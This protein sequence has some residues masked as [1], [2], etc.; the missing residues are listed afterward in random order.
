LFSYIPNTAETSFYGLVKQLKIFKSKKKNYIL[1]N[2]DK[3]TAD[4]LEELLSVKIR[5]GESS[6]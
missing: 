3:L 6:D 4:S 1:E 5:T 2:T